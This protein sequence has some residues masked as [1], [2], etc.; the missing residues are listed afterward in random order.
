MNEPRSFGGALAR[1]WRSLQRRP[2]YFALA[3]SSLAIALGLATTVIAQIDSLMHPYT[4]MKEPE[5]VY[6]LFAWGNGPRGRPSQPDIESAF[7]ASGAFETLA[8]SSVRPVFLTL[9]VGTIAVRA[10]YVGR[11]FLDLIGA[12]PRLGR[13]FAP[14]ETHQSGVAIVSDSYW[15][16]HFA[17]ASSLA[18]ASFTIDDA[19]YQVVGVLDRDWEAAGNAYVW[20]PPEPTALNGFEYYT[21][22]APGV[23]E[24]RARTLMADL[25]TRWTE[26]FGTSQDRFRVHVLSR[27]PNP[28]QLNVFHRAMIAAAVFILVIAS[29]NVSALMLARGISNRRNQALRLALGASKRDLLRDVAAEVLIISASAGV[30]G[31]AIAYASMGILTAVTP[32]ELSW[33]GLKQ[34]NWSPRV[35]ALMLGAVVAS[36]ALAA[37]IPALHTA[38]IAPAEP[39]KDASGTTTGRPTKRF[40]V[41]VIGE[42]ALSMVLLFVAGVMAK[43]AK[44]V[45]DFDFGYDAASVKRID[46]YAEILPD[47]APISSAQP[48]RVQAPPIRWSQVGEVIAKLRATPGVRAAS[49]VGTYSATRGVV[50]SDATAVVDSLLFQP[51]TFNIGP[52]Y[53]DALGIPIVAGRDFVDGDRASG[54][55]ILDQRAARRLFPDNDAV[56]R[57]VRLGPL[58]SPDRWVRVVGIA[59]N[60]IYELPLDPVLE[61]HPVV[62]VSQEAS[63]FYA[64]FIIRA[65]RG[66]ADI[67]PAARRTVS[68][69]LPLQ[70][71]LRGEDWIARYASLLAA[72]RF[73]AGLFTTL[74]LASLVLAAAGLF[75]VMSYAVS[76]RMR[77]FSVR[78]ALGARRPNLLRLVFRDG[79]VMA[80]G[81]TGLGAALGMFAAFEVNAWL[82]GVYPVDATALVIAEATVLAVTMVACAIPASRAAAANPVDVMRAT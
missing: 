28:L 13:L 57:M 1:A 43:T 36:V 40:Q 76:Q 9:P 72:R 33:I 67:M 11:E 65:E 79:L 12:K 82:W 14:G 47:S 46:A 78:V 77:E 60:A 22:L 48:R 30:L 38:R 25:A 39:L 15:R 61:P 53:F 51:P 20:L 54:A 44:T 17:N 7:R 50:M 31:V 75:G 24:K 81:G 58:N 10:R 73:T 42:L 64:S 37:A 21:R 16:Q 62:Y 59:R 27:K 8:R 80:L 35:F 74:S 56:G 19:T 6:S 71:S 70:V 66:V 49:W 52:G 63:R 34:P 3:V 45:G 41:L 5:R 29:A 68:A 2:G 23:S 69:T 4:P 55:V 26:Q 32:V 18:G